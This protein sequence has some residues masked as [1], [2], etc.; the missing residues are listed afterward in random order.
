MLVVISYGAR[1]GSRL[2]HCGELV[3]AW[4]GCLSVLLTLTHLSWLDSRC[5]GPE[6]HMTR[7]ALS[8]SPQPGSLES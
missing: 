2:E 3:V 6:D 8:A 1:Q 4:A 7:S 5:L